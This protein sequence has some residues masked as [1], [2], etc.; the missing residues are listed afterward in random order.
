MS[1]PPLTSALLV[2]ITAA[3]GTTPAPFVASVEPASVDAGSPA[4][5]IV[6]GHDLQPSYNATEDAVTPLHI[7]VGGLDAQ[8]TRTDRHGFWAEADLPAL[9]RGVHDVEASNSAGHGTL[10]DGVAAQ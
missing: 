7:H 2:A 1:R 10:S 4:H 6:H 3:C 9:T 5:V 8:V